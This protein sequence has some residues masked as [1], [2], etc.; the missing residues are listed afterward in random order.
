M[1]TRFIRTQLILFTVASVVGVAVMLF[2]YMQV[3]TLLGIGRI[4]V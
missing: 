1:L 3:P 2:A 4:T